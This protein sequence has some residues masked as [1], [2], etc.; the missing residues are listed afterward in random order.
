MLHTPTTPGIRSRVKH[1]SMCQA[2]IGAPDEACPVE[3]V[4]VVCALKKIRK[5]R[6]VSLKSV[7]AAGFY[8][9]LKSTC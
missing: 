8:M 1:K 5:K 7:L 6:R 2:Q 9:T 3:S 4:H